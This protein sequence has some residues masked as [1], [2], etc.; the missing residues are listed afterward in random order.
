MFSLVRFC[1]RQTKEELITELARDPE[2][3]L[4]LEA[5]KKELDV[6]NKTNNHE[7]GASETDINNTNR[8]SNVEEPSEQ[9]ADTD[10]SPTTKT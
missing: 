1:C 5:L 10:A 3:K 8:S 7:N 2:T 4:I 9:T 6:S